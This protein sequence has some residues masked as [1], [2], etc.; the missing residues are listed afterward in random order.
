MKAITERVLVAEIVVRS[1]RTTSAL[2]VNAH[3]GD[4]LFLSRRRQLV[5]L[6]V[7]DAC[8]RHLPG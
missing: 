6:L 3:R 1:T 7:A 4:G 5:H 8:R 2:E